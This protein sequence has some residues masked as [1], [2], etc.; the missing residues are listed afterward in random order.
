[1][2]LNKYGQNQKLEN[3]NFTTPTIAFR[4][5]TNLWALY[6]RVLIFEIHGSRCLVTVGLQKFSLFT[7]ILAQILSS[8]IGLFDLLWA[9]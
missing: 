6:Y 8:S 2:T 9:L 1:M 7:T 3:L 4:A 5:Y